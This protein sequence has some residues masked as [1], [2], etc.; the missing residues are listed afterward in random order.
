MQDIADYFKYKILQ[1]S[2]Y[3]RPNE[4]LEVNE[5]GF[6][7]KTGTSVYDISIK[8]DKEF[9]KIHLY[10]GRFEQYYYTIEKDDISGEHFIVFIHLGFE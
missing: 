6:Q 10:I 7:W 3:R 9:Y 2:G 8:K 4:Y 5:I 1:H